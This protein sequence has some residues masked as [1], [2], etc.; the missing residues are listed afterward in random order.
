[1]LVLH[2]YVGLPLDE[3]GV[4]LGVPSGTVRS[5]LHRATQAMRA[6]L[7]ADARTA[8]GERRRLA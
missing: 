4:A 3:V 1:V 6:A 5:R 7:E 8:A 2:Y